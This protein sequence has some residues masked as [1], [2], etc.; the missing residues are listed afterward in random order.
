MGRIVTT[1]LHN[2]GMPLIRYQTSD[3]TALRKQKCSCGREFPLME[4]VTTKAE[5]IITTTDGRLISSSILTHP[6]KPM[7]NVAESQ[8]IQEDRRNITIKI[9]R[10]PSYNDEDTEYLLEEFKKRVGNDMNVRVEFVN[11][12]PRTS[13]GKFRW[14]ISKVPLKF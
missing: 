9:I 8:I 13:S 14:V 4:D 10:R 5:D 7:H 1:G 3:I 6:F 12:L 2:F 11:S